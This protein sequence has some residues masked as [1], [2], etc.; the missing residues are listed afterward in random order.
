MGEVD[1][2][3]GEYG[4]IAFH[5]SGGTYNAKSCGS[6]SWQINDKDNIPVFVKQTGIQH[7]VGRRLNIAYDVP[8]G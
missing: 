8:Y 5:N 2:G 7:N 3:P 4:I 1:I 6:I